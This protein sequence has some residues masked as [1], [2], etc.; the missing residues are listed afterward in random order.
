[1]IAYHDTE[2]GVPL[3]DDRRLF[4]YLILDGMQAGLSWQ[5]VLNKREGLRQAFHDFD[6]ARIARYTERD[7]NRLL[8][9]PSVIRNRAKVLAAVTNAR[10]FL[11]IQG[12]FGTFDRY[13]WQFVG[14]KPIR[15]RFKTVAEI[16]ATSPESDAMSKDL[17]TRGFKF[18]GS[19]ICCAFMQGAGLVNDHT[20]DCFR[21][22]ELR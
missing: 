17:Q 10:C 12:E 3:H 13:T 6:P 15:H 16:P 7:L 5:V 1:M 22:R 11:E 8:A 20:T 21:Y 4:E 18:V 9:D 19:T 14:G 2:W